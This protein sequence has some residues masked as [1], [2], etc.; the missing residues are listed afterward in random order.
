MTFLGWLF[1]LAIIGVFVIAALRLVPVYLEYYR[2]NTVLTGLKAE[3]VDGVAN[4]REIRDYLYK[5][6]DIEAIGRV[7]AKDLTVTAKSEVY[8]VRANYDARTPFIGNVHFIIT[9][10]KKVEIPR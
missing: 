4:K 2:I 1:V 6:F 7:K 10:D 5:R 8:E 9:F 3:K